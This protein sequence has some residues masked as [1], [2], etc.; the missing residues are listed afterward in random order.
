MSA[1]L[2]FKWWLVGMEEAKKH[3]LATDKLLNKRPTYKYE[4]RNNHH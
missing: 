3:K 1:G 4:E 2:C